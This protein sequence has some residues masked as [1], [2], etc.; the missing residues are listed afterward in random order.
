MFV[1]NVEWYVCV[2]QSR[3]VYYSCQKK[4]RHERTQIQE[5]EIQR[6]AYLLRIEVLD[7]CT[8]IGGRTALQAKIISVFEEKPQ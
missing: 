5:A 7:I 6:S 1:Y 2:S 3:N 8:S 4:T